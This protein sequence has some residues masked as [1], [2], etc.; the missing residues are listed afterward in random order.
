MICTNPYSYNVVIGRQAIN[1]I[2]AVVSPMH[3]KVKYPTPSRKIDVLTVEQVIARSCLNECEERYAKWGP[4]AAREGH[5]VYN[6]EDAKVLENARLN[7][8]W[9]KKAEAR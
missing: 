8:R 2:R 5:R 1:D 7:D 3:L 6:Y 9:R 4:R